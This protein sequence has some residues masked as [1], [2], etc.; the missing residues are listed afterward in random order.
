VALIVVAGRDD[1]RAARATGR[2]LVL[3]GVVVFAAL[4]A[5]FEFFIFRHGPVGADV[6][7]ALL[8]IGVGA[9]LLFRGQHP[10]SG[11][12]TSADDRASRGS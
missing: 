8:L 1:D 11:G 5:L 4:A 10:T 6:I 12:A 9:Y 2:G 3:W 7:L